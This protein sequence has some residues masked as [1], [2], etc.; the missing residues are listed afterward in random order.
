MPTKFNPIASQVT[1]LAG[2][3]S[4]FRDYFAK[5]EA[6]E[7]TLDQQYDTQSENLHKSG[8]CHGPGFPLAADGRSVSTTYGVKG[9][10]F[11]AWAAYPRRFGKACLCPLVS[12]LG[13]Q[14]RDSSSA[15]LAGGA[16]AYQLL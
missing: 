10:H 16:W 14:D 13:P 12:G 9:A 4:G 3:K 8:P 11:R 15:A 5:S 2:P 7:N 1:S 6:R